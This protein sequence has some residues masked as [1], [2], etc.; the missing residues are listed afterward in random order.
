MKH[1]KMFG[2]PSPIDAKGPHAKTTDRRQRVLG[3]QLAITLGLVLFAEGI[4][5]RMLW[6]A[7][8]SRTRAIADLDRSACRQLELPLLMTRIDCGL[9]HADCGEPGDRIVRASVGLATPC[10]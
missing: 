1:P 7:R 10:R 4:T 6:A 9:S 2:H 8:D 5:L 3:I